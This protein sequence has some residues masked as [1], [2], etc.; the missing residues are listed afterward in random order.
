MSRFDCLTWMKRNGYETPPKSAC[1]FCPYINNARLREMKN[2]YPEEWEKLVWLDEEMRRLQGA[3]INGAKI[4]G[5]LYIHRECKPLREV[6]L[7]NAADFGQ[8]DLFGEECEG[9]CGV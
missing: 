7:R 4:T 5:T 8:Q 3:V 2:H 1:Y 9:M 6:D